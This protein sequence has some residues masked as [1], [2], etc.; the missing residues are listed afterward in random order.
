M[1]FTRDLRAQEVEDAID[2][3][4]L[5]DLVSGFDLLYAGFKTEDDDR[6]RS[7]TYMLGGGLELKNVEYRDDGM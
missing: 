4:V 1:H 3:T 7:L 6:G 2:N 5:E